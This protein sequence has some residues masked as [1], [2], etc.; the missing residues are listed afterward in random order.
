[1]RCPVL[2]RY[3]WPTT[4]I[5]YYQC[6]F[7]RVALF[8]LPFCLKP[9]SQISK[10]IMVFSAQPD[11][12]S[13]VSKMRSC[14]H[15]QRGITQCFLQLRCEGEDGGVQNIWKS[16][17]AWQCQKPLN[18][19]RKKL[20]NPIWTS[21]KVNSLHLLLKAHQQASGLTLSLLL[22]ETPSEEVSGPPATHKPT[23]THKCST[24]YIFLFK[25]LR[26]SL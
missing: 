14:F 17:K 7:Q 12:A 5:F 24:S 13:L 18:R 21:G 20:W 15:F 6:A 8:E 22:R 9:R 26:L 23:P 3:E 2:A 4:N 1:M 25:N 11:L 16:V 19:Q 10:V